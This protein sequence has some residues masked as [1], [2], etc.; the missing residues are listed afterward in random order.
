MKNIYRHTE[1]GFEKLTS[2]AI[3]ILGN[4]ITFIIALGMV[5]FWLSN[6]KFYTQNIHE[7]I[8]DV[9]LGVTFLSLF[10]IQKTFNRFSGSLHLKVNELVA[11]HEPASNTVINAEEKTEH[12]ITELSKGYIELADQAKVKEEDIS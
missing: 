3:A 1:R 5:I 2:V 4:S 10:I 7:S 12:E 8:G 11:S 6:R 9:I